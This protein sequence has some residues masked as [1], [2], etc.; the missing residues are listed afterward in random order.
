MTDEQAPKKKIYTYHDLQEGHVLHGVSTRHLS[1]LMREGTLED[2]GFTQNKEIIAL[3]TE[4]K[5]G[6]DALALAAYH[7]AQVQEKL[8]KSLTSD[9]K[10]TTLQRSEEQLRRMGS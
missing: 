6:I 2:P 1:Q 5:D 4:I 9:G 3:L 7:D 10:K 8:M